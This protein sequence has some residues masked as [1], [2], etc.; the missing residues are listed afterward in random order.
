[1]PKSI[2]LIGGGVRSGKSAHALRLA[3]AASEQA[4]DRRAF[5]ATA[6]AFDDE[7]R[8]RIDAH[9]QERS[10]DFVTF[11]VPTELPA[12]LRELA[13]DPRAFSVVVVDC[14]T[15]WLTNVMLAE[16]D[17]VHAD[18]TVE[19]SIADLRE[20]VQNLPFDLILVTNE[21]GMGIVPEHPLARRFRDHAGRLHQA[22]S[23]EATEV[24]LAVL[25]VVLRLK[26][27]PVEAV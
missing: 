12:K 19:A 9:V 5:L 21:V 7:M 4:T 25:G 15:L 16:E 18:H 24:H 22:L 17:P 23:Q 10:G 1:M 14:L 11:D 26:P 27:G 13:Q 20:T 2:T 6:I 8:A 3:Y